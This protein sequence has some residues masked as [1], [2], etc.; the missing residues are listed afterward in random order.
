MNFTDALKYNLCMKPKQIAA[1][2]GNHTE[3]EIAE[4]RIATI[5]SIIKISD[6]AGLRDELEWRKV[7]LAEMKF[8]EAHV[9]I[10]GCLHTKCKGPNCNAYL[11]GDCGGSMVE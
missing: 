2:T 11:N 7:Q 3:V 9:E 1:I 5:E 10:G 6:D 4:M 8:L